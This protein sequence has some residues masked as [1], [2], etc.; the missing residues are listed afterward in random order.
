MTKQEHL[1]GLCRA[2]EILGIDVRF[3]Q[4]F[5]CLFLALMF[6]FCNHWFVCSQHW[7]FFFNF[8]FLKIFGGQKSFLGVTG[9]PVLNFWWCLCWVQSQSG[10]SYSHLAGIGEAQ[11]WDQNLSCHCCLTDQADTLL[12][13]LCWLV[14]M[15]VLTIIDFLVFRIEFCF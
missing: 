8:H 3:K 5:T 2:Y 6:V 15:F 11:N 7:R 1:P 13:E 12:T 14:L 10:Q 9:T 4:S